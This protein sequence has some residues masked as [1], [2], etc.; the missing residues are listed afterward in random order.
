MDQIRELGNVDIYV[1]D[2]LLKG[3]IHAN[4]SILDAGCG[5]GRNFSYLAKH[6]FNITG[7]DPIEE[8][9]FR[10]T[11]TTFT[12]PPLRISNRNNH[13]TTLFAMLYCILQKITIIS[14]GSS[15]S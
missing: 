14:I 7:I 1:I 2:Q 10:N 8:H 13:L 11:K 3:A 6:N 5:S 12:P 9:N 15:L 4:Q